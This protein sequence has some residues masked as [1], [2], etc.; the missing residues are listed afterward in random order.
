MTFNEGDNV[1]E[2]SFMGDIS[3]M[4]RSPGVKN[5]IAIILVLAFL[6]LAI[7]FIFPSKNT[8][9]NSNSNNSNSVAVNNNTTDE[10]SSQE[11]DNKSAGYRATEEGKLRSALEK[12][13]GAGKVEVVMHFSSGDVKRPATNDNTQVSTTEEKDSAG[14]TRKNIQNNNGSQVVMSNNEALILQVDNPK[15][16][17][18][19]IVAEGASNGKVKYE[20][21]KA[22]STLYDISLDKVTVTAME[23]NTQK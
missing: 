12:I 10:N 3:K 8:T 2:S 23:T 19:L 17:G 13:E 16:T 18:V 1:K 15:L 6:Y 4:W 9:N 7:T 14:A 22:V 5:A 21:E 11:T 20:I